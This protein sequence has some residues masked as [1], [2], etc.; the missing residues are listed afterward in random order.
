MNTNPNTAPPAPAREPFAAWIGLAWG[1]APH[2]FAWQDAAGHAQEGALPAS[3]EDLHAWLR[4]RAER[5]GHRPVALAIAARRGPV[6][7]VLLQ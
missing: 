5:F 6:L 7:A 4:Q 3:A 1:H 2:A